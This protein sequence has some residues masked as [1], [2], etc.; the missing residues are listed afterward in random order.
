MKNSHKGE[1]GIV[2]GNGPSLAETP[3]SFLE[4]YPRICCNHY[5][6]RCMLDMDEYPDLPAPTYWSQLGANQVQTQ[7]Q[8]EHYY[9]AIEA[10]EAAFVN[11]LVAD[12]FPQDNVHGIFSRQDVEPGSFAK[13]QFSFEPLEYV[14]I[15]YTQTYISL[16][17]AYYL[18]F[19][20]VL[21]VGLDSSYRADPDKRHYYEDRP[22]NSDEPYGGHERFEKGSNFV[23]ALSRQAYERDNRRIINLSPATFETVFEKGSVEQWI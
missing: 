6:C 2:V 14:G 19:T 9:S 20:T 13:R 12:K 10:A 8:R 11:R 23:F 22:H 7:E 4:S 1:T 15:G 17:L 5:H 3:R 21:I 16:Q 18:G